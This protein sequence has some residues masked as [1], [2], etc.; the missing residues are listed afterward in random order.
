MRA[1]AGRRGRKKREAWRGPQYP[2][3]D[4]KYHS[5]GRQKTVRFTDLLNRPRLQVANVPLVNYIMA[6]RLPEFG[7]RPTKMPGVYTTRMTKGK[8]YMGVL[9]CTV[10][11]D[12]IIYSQGQE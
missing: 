4:V 12:Y 7:P 9:A 10:P 1:R 6:D 3:V 5:K 8:K 2:H 11:E